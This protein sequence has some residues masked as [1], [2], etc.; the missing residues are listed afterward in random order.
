MVSSP[1]VTEAWVTRWMS[2]SIPV[3]YGPDDPS[4]RHLRLLRSRRCRA[5]ALGVAQRTRRRRGLAVAA[6]R[7][8]RGAGRTTQPGTGNAVARCPP[9][10]IAAAQG[11]AH[12]RAAG[13]G[14]A[15][16]LDPADAAQ[17]GADPR[18]PRDR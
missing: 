13:A 12:H 8:A 17:P 16:V 11:P 4:C 5:P 18:D 9:A 14:D 6:D 7:C 1:T 15:G 10:R 3:L 2:A